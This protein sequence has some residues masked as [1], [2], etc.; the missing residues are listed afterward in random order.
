[1]PNDLADRPAPMRIPHRRARNL[2]RARCGHDAPRSRSNEYKET[3]RT[4]SGET[5]RHLG[6]KIEFL[7]INLKR[8]G[9]LE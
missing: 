3:S 1:M 5:A 7:R 8:G 9:S 2:L 4:R 6:A